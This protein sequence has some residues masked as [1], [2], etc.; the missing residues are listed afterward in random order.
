VYISYTDCR[1][2][3]VSLWVCG[4]AILHLGVFC[5]EAAPESLSWVDLTPCPQHPSRIPHLTSLLLLMPPRPRL[6]STPP[7]PLVAAS[8]PTTSEVRQAATLDYNRRPSRSGMSPPSIPIRGGHR[9]LTCHHLRF[10]LTAPASVPKLAVPLLFPGVTSI[11]RC[12]GHIHYAADCNKD[13]TSVRPPI[14]PPIW[15]GFLFRPP[16]KHPLS[17]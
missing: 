15:L 2:L 4:E 10:Q 12:A 1:C 8:E 16:I 17:T 13:E 3:K 6:P 14:V 7:L 11:H 5:V 9:G